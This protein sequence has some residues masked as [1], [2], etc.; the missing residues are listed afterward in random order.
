LSDVGDKV[1]MTGRLDWLLMKKSPT[2]FRH[3]EFEFIRVSSVAK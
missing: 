2:R 1:F 3:A